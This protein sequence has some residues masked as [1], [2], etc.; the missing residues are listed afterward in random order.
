MSQG[1]SQEGLAEVA[2]FHRTYV[3]QAERGVANIS[4]D[5]MERLAKALKVD[6]A[7]LLRPV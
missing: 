2:G 7:D 3:S 5:N 6:V 4:L 1:I